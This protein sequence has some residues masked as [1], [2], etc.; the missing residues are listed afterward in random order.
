[1]KWHKSKDHYE[2]NVMWG[3]GHYRIFELPTSANYYAT[4]QRERF[5]YCGG[6][7]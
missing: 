6:I 1:M 3:N 2:G 7:A 4:S 5:I